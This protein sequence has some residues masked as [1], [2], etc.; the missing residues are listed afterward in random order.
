MSS[1]PPARTDRRYSSDAKKNPPDHRT[2]GQRDRDRLLYSPQFRR[3]AEVT[4]VVGSHETEMFHNRLTHTLE[5]A[6]VARRIAERM[7]A[8]DDRLQPLVDP[9]VVE[10][11][12]LAHDIGH[13]PFGHI[14]ESL[15]D[16]LV[17]D[18]GCPA[19]FEGNAQSFR[20]VVTLAHRSNKHP[21]LDLTRG[22]LQALSKYPWPRAT[23]GKHNRKFG[24]Y[25]YEE[26]CFDWSREGLDPRMTS[27]QTPE[28]TIMDWAD[29]V[30]YAL[31]DMEDFFMVGLIPLDRLAEGDVE[32][33]KFLSRTFTRWRGENKVFDEA[34]YR[35]TA[36][37]LFAEFP[38]E[39]W[40]ETR[41][42]GTM[43]L[44]V[45]S[46]INSYVR[47]LKV[48]ADLTL[49]EDPDLR[50]E[51]DLLK[52]LAW[53]YVIES[54]ALA[55][56]QHGQK[57]VIR[58]LF[59]YYHDV[60]STNPHALP[61]WARSYMHSDQWGRHSDVSQAEIRL[62]CDVVASLSERQAAAVY[63]RITGFGAGS[64]L[65]SIFR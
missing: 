37:T 54:P 4:Q 40:A 11:A 26:E 24:T 56:Q 25:D 38:V 30:A 43:D 45:P 13:P 29:D 63:S 35:Q 58:K 32:Q 17:V 8:D 23:S 18:A 59:E 27:C 10:T 7:V 22:T 36:D 47:G 46:K 12:A 55:A 62:A 9:D 49:Q 31:H 52:S 50:R 34:A 6:Q 53:T 16:K 51:I 3:L 57:A 64:I 20:I 2:A 39:P 33:D 60:V 42:R 19:G 61:S 15:L 28:A 1:K 65:E 14:A 44:L 5:V 48:A 41:T 21:G